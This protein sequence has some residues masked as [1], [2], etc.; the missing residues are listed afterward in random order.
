MRISVRML[1]VV[2]L[3]AALSGCGACAA[4]GDKNAQN[5]L[6]RVFDGKF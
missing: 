2:L 3:M 1:A 5:V 6:C 4:A